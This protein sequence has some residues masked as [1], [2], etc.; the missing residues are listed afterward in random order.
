[1][2]FPVESPPYSTARRLDEDPRRT[3]Y[4]Y[5]ISIDREL[6]NE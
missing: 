4:Y 6:K 2:E 5:N 3:L 1:M